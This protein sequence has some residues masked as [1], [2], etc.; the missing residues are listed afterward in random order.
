MRFYSLVSVAVSSIFLFSASVSAASIEETLG[1]EYQQKKTLVEEMFAAKVN[2]IG[3]RKALP[4]EIRQLLLKQAN[5]VREFDLYTLDRKKDMK[6][7][8]A[9]ERDAIREKLREEAQDRVKWILENEDAFKTED[10]ADQA[11]VQK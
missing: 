6:I 9:K 4:E 3:E 7:R 11:V 8:H 2:K 10:K 1:E 5:E